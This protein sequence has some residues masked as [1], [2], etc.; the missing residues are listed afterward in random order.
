[1]SQARKFLQ[2]VQQKIGD[3]SGS[4]LSKE[5]LKKQKEVEQILHNED[6]TNETRC[7]FGFFKPKWL[8]YLAK[9]EMYI[10]VYCLTGMTHGMFFTYTVSVLSTI[11]KRFGLT[12]KET[13]TILSGNDVSQVILSIILGYYGNYGHRTRWMSVGALMAAVSGFA[14][15]LPH[16]IYGPGPD[17]IAIAQFSKQA[18]ADTVNNVTTTQNKQELCYS[19]L[20]DACDA[21]GGGGGSYIGPVIFFFFSQFCVG[22]TVSMFYSIGVTYMDDNISKKSYPI[23]YAATFMLRILGPVC[24]YFVGGKCLSVWIDPAEQPNLT[25]KDPRWY[26]AWWIGYLFFG[27]NL[28]FAA[29]LLSLFPKKL[30]ATLKRES[31]RVVRQAEKD[32]KAGSNRGLEYFAALAKT[33]KEGREKPTFAN[34]KKALKRIFTNKIWVGNLFN[35]VV[36]VIAASGY[37]NFKPKYLE[38]QFRKSTSDSSYYTGVTSLVSL[39]LGT[40]LGGAVLRWAK[41]GPR[42]VTGY[43]IFITLLQS[44][45]YIVLMF[46]GCPKLHVIGPVEGSMG[47]HCS[48]DC[49][50]SD[51]FTPIC[52]EDQKTLFYSPCYAG[53]NVADTTTSPIVYSGCRC[54]TTNITDDFSDQGQMFGYAT[55]GYCDETCDKF[56]YYIIIQMIVKTVA[57]TGRVGS[58]LINIRYEETKEEVIY[59][60]HKSNDFCGHKMCRSHA[61]CSIATETLRY[62]DPK[63]CNVCSALMTEGFGD[64]K[65]TESRDAAREKLR[66]W[67]QGFQKNSPGPYLL[68][69]LMGSMLF[70]KVTANAVVPQARPWPPCVQL[71]IEADINEGLKGMDIHQERMSEVSSDTEKDLLQEDPEVEV[72]QP[73][74]GDEGLESTEVEDPLLSVL[75]FQ[76]VPSTSSAP[77]PPSGYG[78]SGYGPDH[79]ASGLYT[80]GKRRYAEGIP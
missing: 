49:G 62:W 65:T 29:S 30:P 41:P 35:T 26:G 74:G 18:A 78:S 53:C 39:V 67:V 57:S 13:G 43:N 79:D 34:L 64:P 20:E 19:Q 27:C 8:Q 70:P 23:Y 5:Q 45:S 66:K 31:K 60:N 51:R 10:L 32:A 25:R 2:D 46:I 6:D 61:P 33:K 71:A 14:A 56:F 59:C 58:S 77:T 47:P 37:W 28:I 22:V 55:S 42:F 24:G 73:P 50:C 1:M 16:F 48:A 7:G 11:E 52:S 9:K 76:P 4:K 17:A 40:G 72:A 75:A 44:C 68:S 38:N 15:A 12:S 63:D 21:D 69:E 36:Y 80:L 3:L 54:I